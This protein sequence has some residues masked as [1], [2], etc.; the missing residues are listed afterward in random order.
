MEVSQ[1]KGHPPDI[2]DLLA[3]TS[4]TFAIAIPLLPEPTQT[5]VCLAY[6]LFRVV[7]T[8]EDAATWTRAERTH[9]LDRFAALLEDPLP[10]QLRGAAA[11]WIERGVSGNPGYLDLIAALP[12]LFGEIGRLSAA[13]RA[14]LFTHVRRTAAGMRGFI[15]RS[16]ERGRL[17]LSTMD[18]LRAY[19]YVVAGIVGELLTELFLA[20]APAVAAVKPVLVKHQAAFGEALQLVNILKDQ[21]DDEA[22]GRFYVP[23][24]MRK[25]AMD[26][27]RDD[28]RRAATYVQALRHAGAP[29]GFIAFTSFP[30]ALAEASLLQVERN[31]PGAKVSRAEVAELLARA[32]A[33]A[34]AGHSPSAQ[35]GK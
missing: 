7:D 1:L 12:E 19:C 3:R 29:G 33:E 20:G 21:R 27:A 32:Q 14:I 18:E 2:R 31:G 25:D 6:L 35:S 9:A 23:A 30:A 34:E 16:D 8:L 5:E 17:R 15:E 26:L 13:S 10:G 11:A 24:G 22:D 4:R 28:L